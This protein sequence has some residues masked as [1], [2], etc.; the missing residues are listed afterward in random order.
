MMFVDQTY[1]NTALRSEAAYHERKVEQ[2]Q[3]T[4]KHL[5]QALTWE[6]LQHRSRLT[7][8]EKAAS[9]IA[10]MPIANASLAKTPPS[11]KTLQKSTKKWNQ[12]RKQPRHPAGPTLIHKAS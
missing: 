6:N 5:N 4:I 12:T 11:P 7:E 1:I 2:L 9:Q 10:S 3:R 8:L